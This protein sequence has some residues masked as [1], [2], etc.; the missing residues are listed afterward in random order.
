MPFA[1]DDYAAVFQPFSPDVDALRVDAAFRCSYAAA[2][3][4]YARHAA[5]A[6][7]TMLRGESSRRLLLR[8]YAAYSS[9]RHAAAS[10]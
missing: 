8:C 5:A 1:A 7:D 4:G 6:M 10:V 3:R 2:I 9:L